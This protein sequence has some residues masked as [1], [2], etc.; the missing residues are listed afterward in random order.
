MAITMTFMQFLTANVVISAAW[1]VI[2]Y[3]SRRIILGRFTWKVIFLMLLCHA[4]VLAVEAAQ[5]TPRGG[6]HSG[7]PRGKG[8]ALSK[9]WQELATAKAMA[10][11]ALYKG[12]S[13]EHICGDRTQ[14]QHCSQRH[15]CQEQKTLKR[16]LH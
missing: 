2:K 4:D 14:P 11:E 1:S 9:E 8:T 12:S 6:K 16:R 3:F 15:L 10:T 13:R 5:L 7:S